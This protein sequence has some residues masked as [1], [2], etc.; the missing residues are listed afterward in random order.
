MKVPMR[1]LVIVTCAALALA[2]PLPALAQPADP[3]AAARA[4]AE[5]G[6][7]LFK[8]GRWEDAYAA[9]AEADRI[10]HAPSL[11]SY[12][13]TCRRNQ[14]RLLEAKALYEKVLAETVPPNAPEAFKKAIETART[15]VEKLRL[16]IPILKIKLT[17]AAAAGAK[18]TV[19]GIAVTAA[20]LG[21]GK[22]VDPGDHQVVAEGGGAT[23]NAKVTMKE[24]DVSVVELHLDP[25]P[26][27]A[28][29]DKPISSDPKPD[30]PRGSMVPAGIALGLG[31]AGLA[32][33]AVTGLIALSK[34][35]EAHDG[36]TQPD[37]SGV[38]HCPPGNEAAASSAKTLTVVSGV[39]F[40]LAGAGVITGVVLAIVRPGGA[41][42]DKVGLDVG[43]GFVTVRG[44]F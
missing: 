38:R 34:I 4:R 21:A 2:A 37:A 43:P 6:L 3:Q 36:C 27:G 41:S 8:D 29:P 20:E 22:A 16:R 5:E 18:V 11:A 33:G 31:G 44:R 30:K 26:A 7:A 14:G 24:A 32:M 28:P 10:Y 23:A 17:G 15:E 12:M 1:S 25:A 19:D 9:F 13:G 42:S 39:G 40:G 35:S